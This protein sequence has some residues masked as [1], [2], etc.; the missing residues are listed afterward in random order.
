MIADVAGNALEGFVVESAEIDDISGSNGDEGVQNVR[1]DVGGADSH[2]AHH[3][4]SAAAVLQNF[5]LVLTANAE[6]GDSV[7]RLRGAIDEMGVLAGEHVVVA[8]IEEG[9][10]EGYLKG[11]Y[12][13]PT[14]SVLLGD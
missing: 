3:E 12:L 7:D 4:S 8:F 11:D 14:V 1:I 10:G 13:E 2:D 6:E 5:V 9:V